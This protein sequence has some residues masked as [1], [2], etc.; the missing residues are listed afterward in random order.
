[1]MLIIFRIFIMLLKNIAEIRLI[2]LQI[3]QVGGLNRDDVK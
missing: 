1:L 3:N 2:L